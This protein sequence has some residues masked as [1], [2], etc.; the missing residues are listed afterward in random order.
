MK[1][2]IKEGFKIICVFPKV[3]KKN[4]KLRKEAQQKLINRLTYDLYERYCGFLKKYQ[5]N[6]EDIAKGKVSI[7]DIRNKI[8]LMDVHDNLS[9]IIF[10][11]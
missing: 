5:I 1:R 8:E 10:N 11:Q 6:L 7:K 4:I 3:T 9:K 2:K